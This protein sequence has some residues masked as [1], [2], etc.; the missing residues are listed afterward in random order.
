MEREVVETSMPVQEV[1]GIAQLIPFDSM[2]GFDISV[3]VNVI[4]P[5][6]SLGHEDRKQ[7]VSFA[8]WSELMSFVRQNEESLGC[9]LY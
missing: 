9:S 4:H 2:I 3:S 8:D 5:P 1:L 6:W 7:F